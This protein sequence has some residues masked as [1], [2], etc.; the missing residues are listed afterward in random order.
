MAFNV[1]AHPNQIVYFN[2]L[3]GGPRGAMG[4]YD[5]DYWGNCL[6]EA[7][8]WTAAAARAA[9]R[10]VTVSGNPWPLVQLD[11]ERMRELYFS[12][13]HRSYEIDI[14]LNR[15]SSQGMLDLAAR[16]DALYRV[17]TPDGAVLCVVLRGPLFH[18]L[19]PHLQLTPASSHAAR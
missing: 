11:V 17:E 5:L 13:P 19:E 10:P 8:D 16:D 15:G 18:Q 3:V 9:R 6:L 7:V 4:R 12:P 1:R 14:R 2:E